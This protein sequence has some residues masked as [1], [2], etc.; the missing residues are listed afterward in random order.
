GTQSSISSAPGWRGRA[1]TGASPTCQAAVLTLMS[2]PP[3]ASCARDAM[4]LAARDGPRRVLG[5]RRKAQPRGRLPAVL[6]EEPLDD[7][8]RL[9]RREEPLA[10]ERP[11]REL[12]GRHE[13][14]H[15]GRE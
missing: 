12:V 6:G 15:S 11:G 13:P 3:G 10:H 14:L 5:V 7:Q 9:A 4:R 1:P 8:L 2:L